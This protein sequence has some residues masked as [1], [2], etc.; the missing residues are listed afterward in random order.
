MTK[1]QMMQILQL[2]QQGYGSKKIANELNMSINTVKSFL[3]R[4]LTK[5]EDVCLNCGVPIEQTEHRKKKKFCSDKCRLTWWNVHK[6][7]LSK[8]SEIPVVCS[9]CGKKFM[10]YPSKKRKYCSRS[11]SITARRKEYS[12][13]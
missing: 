5:K 10:S 1:Q 8:K 6:N 2:K 4:N 13:G 9:F 3:K 7:Q 12:N 11:C